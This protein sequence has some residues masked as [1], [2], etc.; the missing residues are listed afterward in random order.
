MNKSKLISTLRTLTNKELKRFEAY[1]NS[2]FFNRIEKTSE[3]FSLIKKF[4]PEYPE[5]K[6]AMEVIF[7]KMYPKETF[8]E[9]KLR[10]VMTDLTK[11]LE[12]Y[13]C[14]LEYE[15]N[16]IYKKHLL[17]DTFDNRNLDKYFISTLEEARG[18]QKVQPYRDVNYFFN[19]HLIEAN[20]YE[21]SL[22]RK[23]RA[24]SSSLQEAVDNLDYYYL[25]NRLRYSCAILS[26]ETLLQEKYN[27]LFLDQIFEFLSKTD[28]DHVPSVSIYQQIAYTYLDADNEE[29]YR[30]LNALL[31]SYSHLFPMEELKD[32]YTH[33]INYCLRK[34]N[35]GKEEL[36]PELM[37]VYKTV[38]EKEII[39]ENGYLQPYHVKNIVTAALRAGDLEWAEQFLHDYKDR[40]NP[41]FR[42]S[43]Y[44]YNMANLHYHRKEFSKALKLMQAVEIN[45][46]YY[47]LGAKVLLLKT[48]FEL[49]ES[50]PFFSLVDAFTNYLKRN[51]L[52]SDSQR[53][54]N[55][56]F[57]K[58]TK[59]LMQMRLGGKTSTEQVLEE[60]QNLKSIANL[61]WL[62][63]KLDEISAQ[64][65]KE[66]YG[67][68]MI[69]GR[70]K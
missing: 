15:K 25:S 57:V 48:Y 21:H 27:N 46:I 19:Q 31:N 6:V 51:K 47:H 29:H 50:E 38:I 67:T 1:I 10:Y 16:D 35:A 11:L 5:N 18:Q 26:R 17:L 55:L 54:I 40:I 61:P 62:H 68:K 4:A 20:A 66:G 9:Q 69:K 45:D 32:I 43:T 56:N 28:L 3:L 33:S 52:I 36:L 44:V 37:D 64:R 24:I 2:P 59:K 22:A 14:Y 34:L 12:D 53:I 58:Y 60:L 49:D 23:P 8:D 65:E 41:E 30:K 63:E 7:P 13:L 39:F 70:K 42:E